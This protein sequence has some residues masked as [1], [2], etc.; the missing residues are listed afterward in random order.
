MMKFCPSSYIIFIYSGVHDFGT[1]QL[2]AM[3]WP[4]LEVDCWIDSIVKGNIVMVSWV[5]TWYKQDWLQ[6]QCYAINHCFNK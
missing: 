4:D 2:W 3:R 6:E 1:M 5:P